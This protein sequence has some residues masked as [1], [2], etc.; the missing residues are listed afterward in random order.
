MVL[1]VSFALSPVSGT[2]S[3]LW[4]DTAH[5]S[6]KLRAFIDFCIERLS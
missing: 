2:I 1:T 6:P 3:L 4:H 5:G